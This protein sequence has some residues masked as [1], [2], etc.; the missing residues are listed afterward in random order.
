MSVDDGWE[1]VFDKRGKPYGFV[2]RPPQLKEPIAIDAKPSASG[3]HRAGYD[4]INA[5]WIAR[6]KIED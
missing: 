6:I 4:I 5:E 2:Y 3:H 1:P